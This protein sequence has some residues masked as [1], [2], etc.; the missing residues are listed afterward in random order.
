VSNFILCPL[1]DDDITTELAPRTIYAAY[2][3]YCRTLESN[4]AARAALVF[5]GECAI[6]RSW[7]SY[8][9]RLTNERVV[10]RPYQDAAAEF[11]AITRCLRAR[12][13]AN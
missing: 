9:Q 4:P 6:C 13:L 7:V 12:D 3:L 1:I 5:D 8:W 10:Y 2:D 11:P